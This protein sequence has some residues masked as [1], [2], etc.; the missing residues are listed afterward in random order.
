[1]RKLIFQFLRFAII[2]FFVT[3]TDIS[4]LYLF[5][6]FFN[7]YYIIS[8]VF[9]FFIAVS[10]SFLLNRVWTFKDNGGAMFGKKYFKFF[11]ISIF[12]AGVNISLLY[13]FTEFF[14]I[15]Y[16]YSQVLATGVSLWINFLGNKF[17]TFKGR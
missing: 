17:W 8:A 14:L 6:E 4:F 1:M 10:L 13:F 5:T 7:I 9:A 3:L 16:L 11:V 12:A 2:G 15:Y